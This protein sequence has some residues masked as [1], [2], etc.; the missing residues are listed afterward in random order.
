MTIATLSTPV[1]RSHR[2]GSTDEEFPVSEFERSTTSNETWLAETAAQ[3]ATVR[4]S[5]PTISTPRFSG[6]AAED[7]ILD[8]PRA[9]GDRI[10][11]LRARGLVRKNDPRRR[12]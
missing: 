5:Y 9:W 4:Y 3:P 6:V 12:L 8:S 2:V 1:A 7:R 10:A 11:Q